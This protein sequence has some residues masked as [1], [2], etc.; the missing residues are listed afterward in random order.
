MFLTLLGGGAFGNRSDWIAD[1]MLHGLCSVGA[2]P[3][4][5]RIVSHGQK[6]VV[7]GEVLSRWDDHR[8]GLQ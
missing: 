2:C 7:A 3:L 6:S 5:V 4:D 8:S 1:A